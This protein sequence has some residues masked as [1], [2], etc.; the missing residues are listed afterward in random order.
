MPATLKASRLK[1]DW[2]KRHIS[3]LNVEIGKFVA[4]NPYRI[5]LE[6]HP[7]SADHQ[8]GVIRGQGVIPETF[9]LYLGDAVHN[10]R[11]ALDLMACDLV[12]ANGRNAKHV[13]FPF[14]R[15]ADDLEKA[16][17]EGH[18]NRASP[19]VL[20]EI[21]LLKPYASRGND[22]LYA[23][24]KLDL[25]DKHDL[26]IPVAQ[27]LFIPDYKVVNGSRIFFGFENIGYGPIKD[28][29]VIGI[30]PADANAQVDENRQPSTEV[31]FALDQPFAAE[32]VIK[33]LYQFVELV[34]GIVSR[35]EALS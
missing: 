20:N 24:H 19:Q 16:I 32:P 10:L 2:A 5:V 27:F 13:R 22:A 7:N 3:D 14:S 8:I 17:R 25:M 35:F 15:T 9:A 6:P 11:T 1:I 34:L 31:T 4:S 29:Q 28:G 33:T 30:A 12:R 23:L 21:R 26:I 18:I